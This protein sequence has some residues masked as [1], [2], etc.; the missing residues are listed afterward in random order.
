MNILYTDRNI[1][2]SLVLL[3]FLCDSWFSIQFNFIRNVQKSQYDIALEYLV[4]ISFVILHKCSFINCLNIFS[5]DTYINKSSGGSRGR[6]PGVG[7]PFS[8]T[9]NAFEWGQIVGTPTLSW[10]G[11]PPPFK[12]A[13]SAPEQHTWL[14][15]PERLISTRVLGEYMLLCL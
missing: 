8:W 7:T 11:T 12:I 15:L 10:V 6:V 4:V 1:K 3:V 2:F 5:N 13:G 9:I 14:T